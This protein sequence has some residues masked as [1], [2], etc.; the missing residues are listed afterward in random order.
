MV[1]LIQTIIVWGMRVPAPI[2][3]T[4]IKVDRGQPIDLRFLLNRR[5]LGVIERLCGMYRERFTGQEAENDPNL[6]LFL[7]D[8][9]ERKCWSAVSGRLPTFRRN[10][11]KHWAVAAKRWLTAREKLSTLGFPVTP[12]QALAMGVPILPVTENSRASQILGNSMNFSSVGII[13]LIALSCFKL[14]AWTSNLV[15]LELIEISSSLVSF[16]EA[17]TGISPCR[18]W[19]NSWCTAIAKSHQSLISMMMNQ[20]QSNRTPKSKLLLNRY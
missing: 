3:T 5:E 7:G 13:E 16:C 18:D 14:Y 20:K 6:F 2:P 4:S 17:R 9:A 19:K 15:T 1:W 10:S 11:G 12:G 8:S